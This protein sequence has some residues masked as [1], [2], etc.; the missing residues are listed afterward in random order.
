MNPQIFL[1]SGAFSASRQG[2]A[3]DVREYAK[4]ARQNLPL[5]G[6]MANLDIIPDPDMDRDEI[7]A[8]C[9][10][11]Y[12]NQQFLKDAGLAPLPVVHRLD[13]PNWL[14]RYLSDG[15]EYICLAPGRNAGAV[16][17]LQRCFNTIA[18]ASYQPRIHGLG[19]TTALLT[20]QFAWSSTDSSTW[21]KQAAV[22]RVLVPLFDSADQPLFHLRP[23]GFFV[24]NRMQVEPNHIDQ[25]HDYQ[26]DDVERFLQRCDLSLSEVRTDH[27][28]RCRALIAY[29][30]ALQSV[31]CAKLYF[32]S[33]PNARDLLLECGAHDHLLS[34]AWLRRQRDGALERYVEGVRE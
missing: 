15:E 30:K 26:R 20:T 11:S 29:F 9:K 21:A 17:W 4:F 33:N 18:Q 28:A 6:C 34:Y 7:E 10:R 32:V 31:S 22:G 25:L 24:S 13:G 5:I 8:T 27:R 23:A 19:V 12:Q 16:G 14:E 3:I 1:D 2:V